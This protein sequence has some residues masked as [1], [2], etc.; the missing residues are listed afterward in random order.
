MQEQL[1]IGVVR[2]LIEMIDAIGIQKRCAAFDT[3][4]LIPARKQKFSE[5]GAVLPGDSGNERALASGGR[6]F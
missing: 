4:N 6:G 2:I 1:T 5:I 3:M